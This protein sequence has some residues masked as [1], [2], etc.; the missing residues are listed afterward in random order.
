MFF[1]ARTTAAMLT[2]SCGSTSTTQTL[3]SALMS[4]SRTR[5][6]V[7]E[8]LAIAAQVDAVAAR[9]AQHQLSAAALRDPVD[10]SFTST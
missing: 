9:A 6:E 7:L 4:R 3:S 5:N 2:G 8:R 10:I 1:I